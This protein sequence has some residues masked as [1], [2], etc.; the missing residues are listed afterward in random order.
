MKKILE[1]KDSIDIKI[2]QFERELL[3]WRADIRKLPH[4]CTER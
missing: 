1:I 4:C 2:R 3:N